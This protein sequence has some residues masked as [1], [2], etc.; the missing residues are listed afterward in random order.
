[1]RKSSSF[2][3][4]FNRNVLLLSG[5]VLFLVLV[6]IGA[7]QTQFERTSVS[8]NDAETGTA[9][10]ARIRG[11]EPVV[12]LSDGTTAPTRA[13]SVERLLRIEGGDKLV[14]NLFKAPRLLSRRS[15]GSRSDR[16]DS[17]KV[18][19][20]LYEGNGD[21]DKETIVRANGKKYRV[22]N[23]RNQTKSITT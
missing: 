23:H 7:W 3:T 19:K 4:A 9:V 5:I 6:G 12:N 15:E 17:E 13:D 14:E 16:A 2:F 21:G 22:E 8:V 10:N 1:M 20:N 18:E 11:E